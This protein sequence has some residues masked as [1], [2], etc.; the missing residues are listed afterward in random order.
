[1]A[2]RRI[3]WK[4]LL[5]AI[6]QLFVPL[7]SLGNGGHI[8]SISYV[9]RSQLSASVTVLQSVPTTREVRLSVSFHI[10]NPSCLS[11]KLNV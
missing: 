7:L 2:D 9:L 5:V 1:M 4:V 11:I 10:I 8:Y 6:A 3:I